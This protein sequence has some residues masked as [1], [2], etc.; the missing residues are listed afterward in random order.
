MNWV[1]MGGPT[2]LRLGPIYARQCNYNLVRT[3]IHVGVSG[4][5]GRL[6]ILNTT[7][8]NSQL[9]ATSLNFIVWK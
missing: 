7:E 3:N 9:L 6:L 2:Q 1:R 4:I 8:V 5:S